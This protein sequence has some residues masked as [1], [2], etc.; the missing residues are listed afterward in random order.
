[1]FTWLGSNRTGCVNNLMFSHTGRRFGSVSFVPGKWQFKWK[2][3]EKVFEKVVHT[4]KMRK[5]KESQVKQSQENEESFSG[6]RKGSEHRSKRKKKVNFHPFKLIE[7][8]MKT[9]HAK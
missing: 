3:W 1:M 6:Q 2:L 9:I 5:S 8:N 4:H 7:P